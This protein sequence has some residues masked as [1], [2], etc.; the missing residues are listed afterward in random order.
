MK[1]FVINRTQISVALASVCFWIWIA[2]K[3]LRFL[4][5]KHLQCGRVLL[6]QSDFID[7]SCTYIIQMPGKKLDFLK[8]QMLLSR[9]YR[10]RHMYL[11]ASFNSC[12]TEMA[13]ATSIKFFT[14]I[15][16]GVWQLF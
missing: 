10:V 16:N 7:K 1:I 3:R 8:S 14:T 6:C 15:F 5:T 2:D 4:Q 13:L 12:G 11:N 9:S